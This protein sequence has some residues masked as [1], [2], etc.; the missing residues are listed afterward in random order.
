M[1]ESESENTIGDSTDTDDDI[2]IQIPSKE[3]VL[4]MRELVLEGMTDE[5]IERLTE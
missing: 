5:E 1:I 2:Q 4:A 3:E